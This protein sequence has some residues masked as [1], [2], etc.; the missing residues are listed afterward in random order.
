M[1]DGRTFIHMDICWVLQRKFEF[2]IFPEKFKYIKEKYFN[3]TFAENFTLD[4]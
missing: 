4:H 2:S 3:M 1:T